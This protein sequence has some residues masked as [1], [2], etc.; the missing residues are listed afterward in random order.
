M[1]QE[2]IKTVG[3]FLGAV[4]T[5]KISVSDS[6]HTQKTFENIRLLANYTGQDGLVDWYKYAELSGV[7]FLPLEDVNDPR[8]FLGCIIPTSVSVLNSGQ[9]SSRAATIFGERTAVHLKDRP[10]IEA[11]A[12]ELGRLSGRSRLFV[13]QFPDRNRLVVAGRGFNL[14]REIVAECEGKQPIVSGCFV[15]L[16]KDVEGNFV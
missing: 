14:E 16:V 4:K 15:T 2:G 10:T 9:G 5:G 1:E 12:I 6:S 3:S 8:R 11:L 7:P 13:C